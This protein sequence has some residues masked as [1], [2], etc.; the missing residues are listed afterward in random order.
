MEI[1]PVQM[2]RIIQPT[3]LRKE[4][5]KFNVRIEGHLDFNDLKTNLQVKKAIESLKMDFGRE[6]L[7]L[8]RIVFPSL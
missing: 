6:V 7:Q 4:F 3:T 2:P 1:I 8:S 5:A